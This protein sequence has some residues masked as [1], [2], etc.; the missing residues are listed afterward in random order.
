MVRNEEFLDILLSVLLGFTLIVTIAAVTLTPFSV[1]YIREINDHTE[2]LVS[3]RNITMTRQFKADKIC[4]GCKEKINDIPICQ[5]LIDEY[6]RLSVESCSQ[7]GNCPPET[8]DCQDSDGCCAIWNC[9]RFFVS[10]NHCT[11]FCRQ[12]I[13]NNL[14]YIRTTIVY[15]A[16]ITRSYY[17]GE[18]NKII[19]LESQQS[20]DNLQSYNDMVKQV[21]QTSYIGYYR[22]SRSYP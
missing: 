3:Y 22:T 12:R 13:E 10:S 18:L 4:N 16:S 15:L 19:F 21:N 8:I 5:Q 2:T 14:C 1:N 6:Q 7:Q 11:Q 9:Y 20:F 17:N